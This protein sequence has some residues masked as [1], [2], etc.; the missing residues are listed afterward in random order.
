VNNN[1]IDHV[2]DAQMRIGIITNLEKSFEV[3]ELVNS[4]QNRQITPLIFSFDQLVANMGFERDTIQLKDINLLDELDVLIVRGPPMGTLEQITT[5]LDILYKLEGLGLTII[6]SPKAI[7]VAGDK[8]LSG[9]RLAEVGVPVPRSIVTENLD[10]ALDGF[11]SLGEDVVIKPII[12][13]KGR[14]IVRITDREIAWRIFDTLL[15]SNQVIFM[16]EYLPH[17]LQDIRT[18]VVGNKVIAAMYRVSN[19]W[20]SNISEGA[21]PKPCKIDESLEQLSIDAS[22]TLGCEL[23]GIDLVEV[24][25]TRYVIEVNPSP[26]WKGLQS[27]TEHSIADAI[28]NNI[29]TKAA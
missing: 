14:G 9:I 22:K 26:G 29:L 10:A 18:L 25:D 6:N 27:V 16:Q 7:E 5:K 1:Y 24:K 4:L 13:S 11:S 28:I 20:K 15:R 21:I 23:A 12:G 17:G 2:R 19:N 8:F 3:Q